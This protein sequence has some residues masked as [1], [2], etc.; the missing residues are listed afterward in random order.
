MIEEKYSESLKVNHNVGAPFFKKEMTSESS[1]RSKAITTHIESDD[2]YNKEEP[3]VQ[4]DSKKQ[5][6]IRKKSMFLFS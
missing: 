3:K 5:I 6:S 2:S 4:S 1:R